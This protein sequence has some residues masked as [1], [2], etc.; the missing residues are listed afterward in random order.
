MT[1][2]QP[3]TATDT[4]TETTTSGEFVEEFA[5]EELLHHPMGYWT[6]VAGEVIVAHINRTMREGLGIGQ[7]HAWVLSHLFE[8]DDGLTRAELAAKIA[9]KRPMVDTDV[10]APAAEELLVRGWLVEKA[11]RLALTAEGHA[12]HDRLHAD[13]VPGALAA[14]RRGVSDDDY[15][16]TVRVL[17]RMIHNGG[18]DTSFGGLPPGASRG[19]RPVDNQEK[20]SPL[21]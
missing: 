6:G 20:S 16:R 9:R 11:G 1:T 13:V 5:D 12:T 18:G 14:L 19:R 8:E 10:V 3:H 7:P 2:T 15:V 21:T 17:R 4:T